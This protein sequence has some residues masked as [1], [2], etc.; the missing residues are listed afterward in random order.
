MYLLGW[1]QYLESFGHQCHL[2]GQHFVFDYFHLT[3]GG[4]TE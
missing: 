1:D 3:F 4:T 2:Q